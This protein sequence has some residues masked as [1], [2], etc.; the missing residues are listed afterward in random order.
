MTPFLRKFK[1]IFG[2]MNLKREGWIK[3]FKIIEAKDEELI[4]EIYKFRYHILCE[5]FDIFKKE[6]YPDGVEMDEYDN[7]SIQ[8]AFFDE[9]NKLAACV[10]LVHHS[11]IGYPTLNALN[12][13][14][15]KKKTLPSNENAAEL[16]RI[17]IDKNYRCIKNTKQIINL[18]KLNAGNKMREMGIEYSYGALEK[19]FLRLLLILKMPYKPIGG[20]QQYGGRMRAPC[21]MSTDELIELNKELFFET[22]F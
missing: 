7:Y 18:I 15:E 1:V 14:Q 3:M 6:D 9:K 21:I 4:K 8:Y 12:I 17:F 2:I 20:Y 16:S 5:E 22:V 19:S 11:D 10:R 13:E